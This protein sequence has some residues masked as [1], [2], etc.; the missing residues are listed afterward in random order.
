MT[1]IFNT[2]D[3]VQVRSGSPPG[4]I[5]TTFYVR[6]CKGRIERI[7]G[8]YRNPEELAFGRFDAPIVPLYRV[9]V[10]FQQQDVWPDYQGNSADTLDVEIYEF[11]LEPSTKVKT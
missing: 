11:W 1:A 8:E 6:G 10:R 2:G 4:H 3:A 5:R 7:A 9:R